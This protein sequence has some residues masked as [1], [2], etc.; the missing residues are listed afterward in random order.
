MGTEPDAEAEPGAFY[1]WDGERYMPTMATVSPWNAGSQHGGPPSALLATI[2]D[3]AFGGPEVRLAH[4]TVDFLRPIPRR[5]LTV[6]A[7]MLRPGRRV[8]LSEATL[9]VAGETEVV[10][11]AR[12]WHVG[13]GRSPETPDG[14][15]PKPTP[16]PEA[17]EQR[18]F[19]G[20]TEWGYGEAIEWRFVEGGYG[21]PGPAAVWTRLRIPLL[22]D[23]PLT[24]L[25]RLLTVADSANG[26]SSPLPFQEW[27][28]VPTAIAI[29]LERHPETE[30]TYLDARTHIGPDGLGLTRAGLADERG[31]L[32]VAVQNLYVAARGRTESA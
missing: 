26:L 31:R 19:F 25:Q 17:Q 5:P 9:T 12:A 7:Q 24:G 28:F 32:G 6:A 22:A 18:Y 30:W 21:A 20:L 11:I 8:R 1:D 16:V 13:T 2:L 23:R 4:L 14:L 10:V 15:G 29:T 27:L 3:E